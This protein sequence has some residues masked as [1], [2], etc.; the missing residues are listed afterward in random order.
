[1]A[2]RRID[3]TPKQL[4]F[5]RAVISGCTLS[6]AYRESYNTS[7]MKPASIHR[8][9]SVLMTNPMIAQRIERLQKQKDR[10]VVASS[11]SDRERVL[12]K[13]REFMESAQ[14]SDS[15]KIRAAELLGKSIGLFKEVQVK[16]PQRSVDEL[17]AELQ[18]RLAALCEANHSPPH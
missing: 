7:N 9:A 3:L 5:C 2:S 16:E 15:A 1:M 11:L 12:S 13:L 8:E 4:H 6:D 17:T 14:P 10:A 18:E